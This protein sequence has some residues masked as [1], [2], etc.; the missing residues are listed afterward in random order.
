M[1]WMGL[2]ERKEVSTKPLTENDVK[3]ILDSLFAHI[4]DNWEF[5]KDHL[6]HLRKT[7]IFYETLRFV[8]H[9]LP[10][11]K[12][13]HLSFFKEPILY[14]FP[15]VFGDRYTKEIGVL[16]YDA[17]LLCGVPHM[18]KAPFTTLESE[19]RTRNCPGGTLERAYSGF[20]RVKEFLA[21]KNFLDTIRNHPRIGP[22]MLK[23]IEDFRKQRNEHLNRERKWQCLK[24]RSEQLSKKHEKILKKYENKKRK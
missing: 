7:M 19:Q 1:N 12:N 18:D 13:N 22:R 17:W 16:V 14:D 6:P 20:R 15:K 2:V 24:A 11:N 21:Q 9:S 10:E 4:R 5:Y 8:V 3:T 23:F